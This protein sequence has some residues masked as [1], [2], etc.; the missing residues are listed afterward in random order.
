M[1][2][3]KN[4]K[5]LAFIK[6]N[7]IDPYAKAM[8]N[9]ATARQITMANFKE[10]KKLVRKTPAKLKQINEALKNKMINDAIKQAIMLDSGNTQYE[11]DWYVNENYSH[12]TV[13]FR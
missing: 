10:L 7:L 8:N 9:F 6:E 12:G 13:N 3:E 11:S 4:N 5:D 1:K 2:I